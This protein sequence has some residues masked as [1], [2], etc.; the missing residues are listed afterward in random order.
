VDL[1]VWTDADDGRHRR[2]EAEAH[3]LGQ[4]HVSHV[5]TDCWLSQA[6]KNSQ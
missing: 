5:T 3:V 1:V 2:G 6:R 4:R